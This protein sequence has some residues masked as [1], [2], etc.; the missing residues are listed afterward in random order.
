MI[1]V[2]LN[3]CRSIDLPRYRSVNKNPLLFNMKTYLFNKLIAIVIFN[4][5]NIQKPVCKLVFLPYKLQNDRFP[6]SEGVTRTDL[7]GVPRG[8]TFFNLVFPVLVLQIICYPGYST[9]K[10]SYMTLYYSS[11]IAII[12]NKERITSFL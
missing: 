9:Q 7:R 10:R 12:C 4:G 2:P 1:D 8:K 5:Q 11:S 3:G 6:T